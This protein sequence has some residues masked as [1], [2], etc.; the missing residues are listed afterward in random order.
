MNASTGSPPIIAA[1]L[2]LLSAIF[3]LA[4]QLL[5]LTVF[6]AHEEYRRLS[7]FRI[8]FSIGVTN[9]IQLLIIG[10]NGLAMLLG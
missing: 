7:C 1:P 2:Y 3:F 5:T 6:L 10:L 9:S 8:M 4:L